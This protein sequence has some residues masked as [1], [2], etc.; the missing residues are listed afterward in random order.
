ML[1][2]PNC[3][4]NVPE[5][6]R[7]CLQCGFAVGA[8]PPELPA[9][10][11]SQHAPAVAAAKVPPRLPS[12]TINLKIAATTV[13][14]PRAGR[15]VQLPRPRLHDDVADID[16]ESLKKSFVR[17]VA[18]PGAVVC[19]FCQEALDL[20]GEY[21]VRCGAPVAEAAPPG[22]LLP[23][24]PPPEPPPL[25]D[26]DPLSRYNPSSENATQSSSPPVGGT[27]GPSLI[28]A[29]PSTPNSL[30]PVEP[31]HQAPPPATPFHPPPAE[32]HPSGLMSRFKGLFKKS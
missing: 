21:C 15:P 32:E 2:C 3:Q 17:R 23:D 8:A 16:E 24:P 10:P 12:S 18:R 1:T 6:M 9:R 22:T 30:S 27:A 14:S 29:P 31:I 25:L 11:R 20:A 7:F 19:R 28:E 5:G 26:D 4:A 13:M